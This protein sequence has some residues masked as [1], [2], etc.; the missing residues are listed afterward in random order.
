[1]TILD[2]TP[3]NTNYLQPTK[4][5][6]TFGKLPTVQ[7]FCQTAN[8]PGVSMG[9]I[10]VPTPTLDIKIGGNKLS[11]EQFEVEF[12]VDETIET[13]K[14]LYKWLLAFADPKS[15]SNRANQM[16]LQ[17]GTTKYLDNYSEA[18]LTVMSALNNPLFRINYHKIFPVSVSG[19]QFDV[20]SSAESIITAKATFAYEYFEITSA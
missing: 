18:T 16:D 19:I 7:Y 1:M 11:Y 12:I 14:E 8:I 3:Q 5:M 2:R 6:L 4:Y 13:W 17:N 20:K 10:N 9:S 15:L